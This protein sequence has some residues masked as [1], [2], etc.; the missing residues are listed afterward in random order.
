MITIRY[1][2]GVRLTALKKS[3]GGAVA[4]FELELEFDGFDFE[5]YL[6]SRTFELNLESGGLNF[7]LYLNS[8]VFELDLELDEFDLESSS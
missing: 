2:V 7:D 6:N 5:L 4:A 8:R 3:K 1:F